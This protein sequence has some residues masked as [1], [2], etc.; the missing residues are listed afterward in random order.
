MSWALRFGSQV[1]PN[2]ADD[3]ELM[4][5]S[6]ESQAEHEVE[7]RTTRLRGGRSAPD[8]LGV[9]GESAPVA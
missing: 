1:A 7:L 6:F 2:R 4:A 3:A 5:A 9:D 8:R